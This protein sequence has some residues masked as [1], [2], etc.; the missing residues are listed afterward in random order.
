MVCKIVTSVHA[1]DQVGPGNKEEKVS[2]FL[3]KI[4]VT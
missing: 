3:S 2:N 4:S 1:L